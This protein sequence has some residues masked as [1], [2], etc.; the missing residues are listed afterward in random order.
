LKA[1]SFVGI[2]CFIIGLYYTAKINKRLMIFTV[3]WWIIPLGFYGNIVTIA[4]RFFTI[5]LPAIIIPMSIFLA[6]LLRLKK[7][8]WKLLA[9]ISVLIVILLP[10]LGVQKTF[11]R[12]HYSALIPDFYRW[13]GKSTEP[14][15]W[16]ICCDDGV[17]ISYYAKRNLLNKPAA[18]F[19]HLPPKELI[20]FKKQLDDILNDKKPVYITSMTL[21]DYDDYREFWDLIWKNYRV[22]PVG[23]MPLEVWYQTPYQTHLN[24]YI[25]AKIE[26]K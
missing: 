11:I 12:R 13:L 26:K 15:A 21:N 2:V 1:F 23:E 7:I 24:M 8:R 3:L 17:F 6:H 19:R 22:T 4:P 18:S 20:N 9:M 10:F 25:L 16:I 14:D 5:I